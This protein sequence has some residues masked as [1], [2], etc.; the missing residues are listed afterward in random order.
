MLLICINIVLISSRDLHLFE[1]I[2]LRK[3]GPFTLFCFPK[4]Y[5]EAYSDSLDVEGCRD[6][7]VSSLS[8]E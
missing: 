5:V 2:F 6:N 3:Q 1:I 7:Y 8:A 4:I